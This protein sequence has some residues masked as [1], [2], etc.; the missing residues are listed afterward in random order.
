M[1]IHIIVDL[2]VYCLRQQS[3]NSKVTVHRLECMYSQIMTHASTFSIRG[4]ASLLSSQWS[5]AIKQSEFTEKLIVFNS[6]QTIVL[7][8]F[9]SELKPSSATKLNHST[10][11]NQQDLSPSYGATLLSFPQPN[12]K[13]C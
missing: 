11:G 6:V 7:T 5:R 10:S 12:F 3:R 1:Y 4:V 8:C 13:R 2:V 9:A